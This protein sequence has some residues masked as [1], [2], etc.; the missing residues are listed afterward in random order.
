M[1]A[2]AFLAAVAWG[3]TGGAASALRAGLF[4]FVL[5][6]AAGTGA[7]GFSDFMTL[8]VWAVEAAARIFA[9]GA[10]TVFVL[11]SGLAS[12]LAAA[13]FAATAFTNTGFA[14]AGLEAAGLA[15][16]LLVAAVLVGAVVVVTV[17][18]LAVLAPA[19]LAA[20]DG[21]FEGLAAEGVALSE[22]VLDSVPLRAWLRDDLLVEG[23]LWY[24]LCH[25]ALETGQAA[26][27][28]PVNGSETLAR[29]ER[30]R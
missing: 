8:L 10:G 15:T 4:A 7:L 13:D 5:A 9:A 16:A 3:A 1:F 28:P 27:H 25:P 11:V 2:G 21:V 14:A 26:I 23:I 22:L 24:S 20:A 18:T 30:A 12:G 29:T 17:L 6:G 19:G